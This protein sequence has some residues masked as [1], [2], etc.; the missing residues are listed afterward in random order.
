MINPASQYYRV[1]IVKMDE[2]D[3]FDFDWNR[4]IIYSGHS[5]K[6][7]QGDPV[8][9]KT[10]WEI[11]VIAVGDESVVKTFSRIENRPEAESMYKTMKA[12]TEQL[13]KLEFEAKYLVADI[14]PT[15]PNRPAR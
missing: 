4:E 3:D 10:F 6:H 9:I 12:D 13:S 2:Y 8:D 1:R 5:V 15:T 11:E 14:P 7:F